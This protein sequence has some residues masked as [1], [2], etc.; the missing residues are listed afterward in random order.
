MVIL[1]LCSGKRF[2]GIT[3]QNRSRP[4]LRER[5]GPAAEGSG[6]D[7]A[8]GAQFWSGILQNRVYYRSPLDEGSS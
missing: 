1:F 4:W 8:E 3:L 7:S 5:E 2:W 6:R